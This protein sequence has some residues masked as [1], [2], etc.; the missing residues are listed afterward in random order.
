[1]KRS[2][3]LLAVGLV[4]VGILPFSAHG[5]ATQ[6]S[7]ANLTNEDILQ[8]TRIGL[9]EDVIVTKIEGSSCNFDT[10]PAALGALK[11]AQ[12]PNAVILAML[13]RA[14]QQTTPNQDQSPSSTPLQTGVVDNKSVKTTTDTSAR[15]KGCMAVR[16]IGSHAFRNIMLLGVAGALIS[17]QQYE[18][19]D[20][21]DYPTHIGHKYHGSDLQTIE[22]SGTRIVV[23]DKHYTSDDLHKAC[24]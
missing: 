19:V 14:N 10:S 18:V 17:H 6:T 24:H 8:M 9:S 11:S 16:P 4:Y 13:K 5:Q 7:S 21:L 22:T 3:M 12:V 2:L 15:S 1:M 20:V 23:L